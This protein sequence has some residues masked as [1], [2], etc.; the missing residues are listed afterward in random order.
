[1]SYFNIAGRIH[2]R[3]IRIHSKAEFFALITVAI[4]YFAVNLLLQKFCPDLGKKKIN[5]I[6]VAVSATVAF[7]LILFVL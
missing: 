4:I 7:I 5:I 1:M 2:G 6:S 3:S